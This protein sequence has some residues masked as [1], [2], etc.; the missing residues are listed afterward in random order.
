MQNPKT[1]LINRI[2]KFR[3]KRF[4]KFAR[5]S[6]F[7]DQLPRE[8]SQENQR[9]GIEFEAFVVQR[10][11]PTYFTLVEW[12]SDKNVNGIF[13]LMSK[14]P[15][16]EFYF[17]S[18]SECCHFAIECKWREHFYKERIWLDQFQLDNYNHYQQVTGYQTFV[19]LGVGNLPSS[20]THVYILRLSDIKTH[21][22]H[23]NYIEK[24]RRHHPH[25][26]FF[27]DC[28]SGELR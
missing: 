11:D 10:F 21:K 12:R 20:P 2:L 18:Q 24:Y 28:K 17:E 3:R 14:F 1:Y 19:L 4:L 8:D 15:D 7:E 16:L 27:L 26:S 13:P 22:L 9:K 25:D 5:S 23:E 6:N